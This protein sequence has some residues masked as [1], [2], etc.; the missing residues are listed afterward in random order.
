LTIEADEGYC[1]GSRAICMS[2][3]SQEILGWFGADQPLVEKGLGWTAGRSYFR[4]REVLHFDMPHD[5]AQ[6]FAPMVN[7]QQFYI[8][9]YAHDAM[10]RHPELAHISW[11]SRVL[12]VR[13]QDEGVEVEVE[14]DGQKK[15]IHAQWL[16][17][18]DG[19]RST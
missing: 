13:N 18:C 6:R 9:E 5:P 16:V 7:I 19:G 17:A 8:E 14:F 2:R 15:W 10:R 1:T 4:D 12:D 11:N 3:R